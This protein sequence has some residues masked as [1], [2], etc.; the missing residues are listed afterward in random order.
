MQ[1]F[2]STSMILTNSKRLL[3]V[4][5]FCLNL[6]ILPVIRLSPLRSSSSVRHSQ[7]RYD[8]ERYLT[9]NSST[10]IFLG[11]LVGLAGSLSI[12][13]LTS[14]LPSFSSFTSDFSFF[15]VSSVF[16]S[17]TSSSP[18]LSSSPTSSRQ[19]DKNYI[20]AYCSITEII[21]DN[22]KHWSIT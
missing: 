20:K 19:E 16:S 7:C 15:S 3:V 21:D 17:F 2:S 11:T 8:S 18:F 22:L 5:L 4:A 12:F 9:K 6:L 13:S 1:V 14:S 10:S